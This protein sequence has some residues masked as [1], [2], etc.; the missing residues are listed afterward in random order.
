MRPLNL[1]M[2]AFGPYANTTVLDMRKLG[3]GGIYLITGDTG[4]GKTTIFDAVTFA[5][6]GEASGDRR[7]PGMLRSKYASDSTPTYVELIFLYNDKEYS[8]RRNPR[9]ERPKRT[10]EGLTVEPADAQLTLPT[11]EIITKPRE[12]SQAIEEL[13]GLDRNQFTQIAMIAQ[14]DFLKLLLADTAERQKILRQLFSTGRYEKLQ[15]ILKDEANSLEAERKDFVAGIQQYIEGIAFAQDSITAPEIVKVQAGELPASRVPDLLNCIIAEDDAAEFTETK[16]IKKLEKNISAVEN[17]LEKINLIHKTKQRINERERELAAVTLELPHLEESFIKAF[18]VK[19]QVETL[20]FTIADAE[21]HLPIYENLEQR[22]QTAAIKEKEL[23]SVISLEQKISNELQ[24]KTEIHKSTEAELTQLKDVEVALV[25]STNFVAQLDMRKK[26]LEDFKAEYDELRVMQKSLLE[27][28]AMYRNKADAANR[29]KEVFETLQ[30]AFLDEQAGV[31]AGKLEAGLPCPVCGS[32]K[33]PKPAVLADEEVSEQAVEQAK[34]RVSTAETAE[35]QAS[36]TAHA[37]KAKFESKELNVTALA[38]ELFDEPSSNDYEY[39]FR[40]VSE[41]I[42]NE[43]KRAKQKMD[44]L[45]VQNKRKHALDTELP[46]ITSRIEALRNE[47]ESTRRT[48]AALRADLAANL[49]GMEEMKAQ[50]DFPSKEEAEQNIKALQIQKDNL[51]QAMD[52]AQKKL[53]EAKAMEKNLTSVILSLKEGIKDIPEL[54]TEE[55]EQELDVLVSKK[56]IGNERYRTIYARNQNNKVIKEKISQKLKEL[57][58]LDQRIQLIKPL[59]DTANGKLSG[60]ERIMLETYVQAS[61]FDRIIQRANRRLTV[62]SNA[63]YE[64]IRAKE[65][66]NLRSQTGL[67]LNVIDYHNGSERSVK[68]LS[69]GESFMASLALALGLSDEIQAAAGGIHLDTMF[70]DEGF[71][72]LDTDTLNQAMKVLNNLA[73]S[74]LLVGIISHVS[75]LKER[76]ENQII[77]TKNKNGGSQVKIVVQDLS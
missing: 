30:R 68:T 59:A 64:L 52:S 9:Y 72:S 7:S 74:N 4:A 45:T 21:K 17:S 41:E 56:N 14:G 36:R 63:Q 75:E 50:L 5:L 22:K 2:S 57:E 19:P 71:G 24:M 66:D 35:K 77:V 15:N 53:E 37:L 58:D 10:G 27:A 62:M 16:N 8:V 48:A 28:Q 44:E 11:G 73:S 76:I 26:Q 65:A 38:E 25:K 49:A 3:E 67:D 20:S 13:I 60:K 39:Q 12:V 32:T 31:L 29:E 40:S 18:A 51:Q 61:Y 1:T 69:G 42:R 46:K 23:E 33:H 70:V 47:L 34:K 6:Y 55:L 54:K 43:L